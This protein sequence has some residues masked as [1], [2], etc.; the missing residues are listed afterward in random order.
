MNDGLL[1]FSFTGEALNIDLD[2]FVT[3]LYGMILPLSLMGDIESSSSSAET[4]NLS[5]SSPPPS[6]SDL[7]F[8]ALQIILSPRTGGIAAAPPQRSAAFSKR[9]LIA[10][11][12]W[13]QTSALRALNLVHDLIAK[14]PKLET[15]L[16]AEDHIFDGNYRADVDDP[17]LCHPYGTAFW[18]LQVLAAYHMDCSV[19]IAAK[20]LLN[21][22]TAV[23]TSLRPSDDRCGSY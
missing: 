8:R 1:V 15:L 12:H 13:P 6:I 16:F 14:N 23:N 17:Q 22:S 18:E 11:L 10:S 2:D 9:L 21:Y 20:K 5:I 19:R 7:L 3:Q 4:S